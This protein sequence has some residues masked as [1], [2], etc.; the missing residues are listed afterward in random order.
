MCTIAVCNISCVVVFTGTMFWGLSISNAYEVGTRLNVEVIEV[1][2]KAKTLPTSIAEYKQKSNCI[3]L[4]HTQ[5]FLLRGTCCQYRRFGFIMLRHWR[6]VFQWMCGVILRNMLS[7]M[8]CM[9]L[10]TD[11]NYL[12][13]YSHSYSRYSRP[14]PFEEEWGLHDRVFALRL[15]LTV[16]QCVT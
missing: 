10:C 15:Y 3:G 16:V 8:I 1:V 5:L 11:S 2:V 14:I 9:S 6:R 7:S 12:H 13:S 4:Q